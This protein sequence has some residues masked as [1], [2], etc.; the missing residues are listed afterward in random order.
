MRKLFHVSAL[1][2]RHRA[3]H[4]AAMLFWSV[5]ATWTIYAFI[6][7]AP[8]IVG[9]S[10]SPTLLAGERKLLWLFHYRFREP[11]R[12]EI[13]AIRLP[14]DDDLI[15]KRI[16]ALP[17]EAVHIHDGAVFVNDKL[18]PEP[19]LPPKLETAPGPLDNHRYRI[20]PDC[21]FVLGDNRPDSIDSRYFGAVQK[22][23]IVGK[24]L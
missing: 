9:E 14:Q 24:I 11:E 17:N 16:V 15:V 21:Y 12:G 20:A 1:T 4:L 22:S 13:V 7:Q 10:M 18:L 8:I 2:R 3:L 6:L 5:I 23:W 19:Y